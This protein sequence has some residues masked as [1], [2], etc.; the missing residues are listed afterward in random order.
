M[1]I[2]AVIDRQI[3]RYADTK[4]Y[5]MIAARQRGLL[6]EDVATGRN[7]ENAKSLRNI[8]DG[9]SIMFMMDDHLHLEIIMI[10]VTTTKTRRATTTRT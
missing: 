1:Q 2:D 9:T 4:I 3:D 5:M 7:D 8:D 6:F 10:T